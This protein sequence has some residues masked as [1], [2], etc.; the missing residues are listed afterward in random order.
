MCGAKSGILSAD[1]YNVNR[2]ALPRDFAQQVKSAADIVRIVGD[3]VRLK[4]SGTNW[5]G[6]C[7]FHQEKTP[8][9]S[10][11]Q[12]K[13]F[14]YCFGC[15]AKGDVFRFV[16]ETERVDFLES[17]RRVAAR[18]GIPVP[19]ETP[20]APESPEEKQRA[21]LYELHERAAEFFR[22]QL[23]SAEAAP[24]RELIKQRGVTAE[25][26]KEFALGYAPGRGTALAETLRKENFDPA[27][28]EMSGLVIRRDGGQMIDRF[29]HRWVFPIT[30]DTGRCVAF[31]AR[32]LGDDPPKYLNSPETPI[33]S[34][35]RTL[36][37]LSRAKEH[38][39]RAGQ[40]GAAVLVE[41]YMD[42]IAAHQAGVMNVVASC[43]TAL[44]PQQVKLL[45]RYASEV[46][47]SYDPDT[48]GANATDRS[49]TLLL[50]EGL[51]VRIVRL[52]DN[53]DPDSFVRQRGAD[54]YQAAVQNAQPI[55]RYL[56]NRAL[57]L[58]GKSSPEAKLAAVN[59]VLPYLSKVPNALIRS[60]LLA[61]IAQKLEVSHSIIGD[62][63][64]KAT[65]GRREAI[66]TPAGGQSG[67]KTMPAP[68]LPRLPAAEAMLIRL[69]LDDA[70]ARA[71]VLEQ[72]H[73]QDLV[74]EMEA[75]PVIAELVR[76]HD[77]GEPLDVAA[78]S[79]KL[80]PPMQRALAEIALDSEA[81]PVSH[82][83]IRGYLKA[84]EF[85]RLSRQRQEILQTIRDHARQSNPPPLSELLDA[86]QQLD[87]K[88]AEL[89]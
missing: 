46:I 61:D 84:L 11:S 67:P 66:A 42:A 10:V 54:A 48:A 49:L 74:A 28:L 68:A 62:T 9:F 77:A 70:E 31:G 51:T 79:E 21:K 47:V 2:M 18:S 20:H 39:R 57:E 25:A 72:L 58:H 29:R 87:R 69:L 44:T 55:F 35:S 40:S 32:A 73:Q 23:K 81:R 78:I 50:E 76:L 3:S 83:E 34:K 30:S 8:S 37:N 1:F 4:R 60:E 52:P 85:K 19:S 41:G 82:L 86:K 63:F 33:Y 64:M 56:A 36:Y 14:Y 38:I 88:L 12:A 89:G 80:D 53:L 71:D 59:F 22:E 45:A 27:L 43:G 17:V 75:A 26:A 24:V 6:L 5:S 13:Q 15:G 65:M 16:M 7:P